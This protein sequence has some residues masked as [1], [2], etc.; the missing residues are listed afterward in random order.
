MLQL[1]GVLILELHEAGFEIGVESNGTLAAPDGIDWLCISPKG[2]APVVQ[3]SG[4]ELKL[5]YPQLEAEAQPANFIDMKFDQFFLQPLDD[6][7][8]EANTR[9]AIE[10]CL[11]HP[12]WKLSVQTH[13]IL[14]ID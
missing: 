4:N 8:V 5:V 3:S 1:D 12:Q 11:S 7:D 13:K 14:G 10:Y 2:S 9:L 6:P